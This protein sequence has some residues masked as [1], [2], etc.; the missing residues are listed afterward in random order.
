MGFQRRMVTVAPVVNDEEG[1]SGEGN[2][3]DEPAAPAT[4]DLRALHKPIMWRRRRTSIRYAMT[5][6]IRM[7][8]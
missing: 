1:G 5:V 7:Q 4:P 3:V 2:H 8:D 6:L